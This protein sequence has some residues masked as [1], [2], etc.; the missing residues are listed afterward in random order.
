MTFFT[1]VSYASR[2]TDIMRRALRSTSRIVLGRQPLLSMI[3]IAAATGTAVL[4]STG[5]AGWWVLALLVIVLLSVG[6]GRR[7]P[8]S[9]EAAGR[10]V[11]AAEKTEP[12][13][14]PAAGPHLDSR[15]D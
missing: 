4:Q 3:V 12:R 5:F 9:I 7:R 8:R 2:T 14:R 11:Q 1:H 6:A 10:N 15:S 13:N